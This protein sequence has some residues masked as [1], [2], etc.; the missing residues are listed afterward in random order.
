MCFF[1][2]LFVG[3]GRA[4]IFLRHLWNMA[5]DQ[6]N[7]LTWITLIAACYL[8]GSL[9]CAAVASLLVG[10]IAWAGTLCAGIMAAVVGS[11]KM[12]LATKYDLR[13]D[14]HVVATEQ[15]S[16]LV[17]YSHDNVNHVH[18]QVRSVGGA[19]RAG[20][21]FP[22]RTSRTNPL[23]MVRD[24]ASYDPVYWST[25]VGGGAFVAIISLVYMLR[26]AFT[27]RVVQSVQTG[28]VS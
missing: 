26:A 27:S 2:N 5:L 15:T 12:F 23:E 8:V 13:L 4:A 18:A 16:V 25:L 19:D 24:D 6:W 21:T 28:L 22:L 17:Q 3:L 1:G 14:G 9:L 10:P 7:D 11:R 20:D